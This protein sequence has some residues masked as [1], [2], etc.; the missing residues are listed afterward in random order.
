[1]NL[2]KYWELLPLG[3]WRCHCSLAEGAQTH[4]EWR[5]HA[6]WGSLAAD[7]PAVA[8]LHYNYIAEEKRKLLMLRK[9]SEKQSHESVSVEAH[10]LYPSQVTL[11]YYLLP[12]SS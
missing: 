10:E 1:M 7:I 11:S 8:P 3:F 2:S 5:G 9:S 4:R 6:C 12:S